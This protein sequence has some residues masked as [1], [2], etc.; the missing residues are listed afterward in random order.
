MSRRNHSKDSGSFNPFDSDDEADRKPSS[1]KAASEKQLKNPFDDEAVSKPVVRRVQFESRKGSAAHR[2]PFSD[3]EVEEEGKP[4]KGNLAAKLENGT[5]FDNN[6]NNYRAPNRVYKELDDKNNN[7]EDLRPKRGERFMSHVKERASSVGESAMK[8]AEKF[9]E[10]SVNSA[11]KIRIKK[12]SRSLSPEVLGS[13]ASKGI[14][15]P[16]SEL[17]QRDLL[18]ADEERQKEKERVSVDY[19]TRRRYKSNFVESGGFENQSVQELE[20]Y[21]VYKAEETTSTVNNCLKVAEDIREDASKTLVALHQQGEQITRT[22]NIALNIDH[23]LRAGEKLLGSLGGIFSRKWKPDKTRTITGP[24]LTRDSSFKR[25]GK[26][27]EQRTALGLVRSPKGRSSSRTY[28]VAADTAQAR[29]E[30]EKAKQ[31]DALSDLSNVLDQ[32][33]EMAFDMGSEIGSQNEAIDHLGDDVTELSY[34]VKGANARGR[35]LLGK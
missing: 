10:T 28:P 6:N 25:R 32:L 8:T 31:D 5:L 33:K 22:H 27:M 1:R 20:G 19:A 29:V 26:H 3:G 34:G 21:A 35:R 9:K 16:N 4:K 30:V 12:P 23:D 24:L 14:S 13:I 18:L 15:L 17:Q 11:H 2:N 7:N